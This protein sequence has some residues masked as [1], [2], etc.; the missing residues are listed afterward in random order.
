MFVADVADAQPLVQLAA[1]RGGAEGDVAVGIAG[2]A[3]QQER[4]VAVLIDHR[5]LLGRDRLGQRSVDGNERF[6]AH[7]VV[8]VAHVGGALTIP[9]DAVQAQFR[10]VANP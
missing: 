5:L 10:A 1:E 7:F 4:R 9:D 8:G 6:P 3:G 2:A